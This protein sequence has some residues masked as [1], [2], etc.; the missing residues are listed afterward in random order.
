MRIS[1]PVVTL[2]STRVHYNVP[3]ADVHPRDYSASVR[4]EPRDTLLRDSPVRLGS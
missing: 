2:L 3:M 4:P 1:A